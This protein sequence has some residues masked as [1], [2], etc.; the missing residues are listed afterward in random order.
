MRKPFAIQKCDGTDQR[1]DGP[2]DMERFTVACPRLKKQGRI[3][4]F[5][6]R[7]RLSRDKKGLPSIWSSYAKS[8]VNAKEAVLPMHGGPTDGPTD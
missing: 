2:T 8:L 5:T 1:T 4:G 7:V 6:S 3:H